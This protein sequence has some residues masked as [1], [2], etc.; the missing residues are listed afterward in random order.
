MKTLFLVDESLL[1]SLAIKLRGF[2]YNAKSVREAGLKGE[3][4][5]KIIEWAI[6]NQAVIITADLDFGELWYWHYK[7]KLG[8]IILRMK[9]YKFE[10]QSRIIDFLHQNNLF[11]L[12]TLNKSLIVSSLTRYR[13][14][15]LG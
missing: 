4:D 11:E 10:M 7:G 3:E 8:I 9:S 5:I 15:E 1:P 2:G 6:K 13:I 14:R 12:K